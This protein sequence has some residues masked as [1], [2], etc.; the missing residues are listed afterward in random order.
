M[1]RPPPV[2]DDQS[3]GYWEAAARH[4]LAIARCSRC[5]RNRLISSCSEFQSLSAF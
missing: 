3:A 1:S 2:P 5:G 4:V